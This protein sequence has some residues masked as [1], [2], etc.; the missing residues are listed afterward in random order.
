MRVRA[1]VTAISLLLAATACSSGS[2]TEPL[3]PSAPLDGPTRIEAE[4]PV[5]YQQTPEGAR[6]AATRYVAVLGGARGL[7]PSRRDLALAAVSRNGQPPP[8]IAAR[9]ATR[10]NVERATGVQDALRSGAPV[11][12]A[13]VP[14]MSRVTAYDGQLA[15]VAVWVTA[16]LGTDRLGS[17]DQSWST[18]TVTLEWSGDWKLAAYESAPGPVPA[19][20]QP[21]TSLAV[22]LA[23]TD[24]MAGVFDVVP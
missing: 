3:A 14:V 10:P 21:V 12:A 4:V 23:A 22:A 9:W 15:A 19:L 8:A 2:T 11:I 16:V 13:A 7:D 20:H 1:V 6:A 24:G 18:E 17:L 5:G